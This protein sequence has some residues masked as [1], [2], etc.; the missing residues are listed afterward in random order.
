MNKLSSAKSFLL[1][2][3]VSMSIYAVC[4]HMLFI[5]PEGNNWLSMHIYPVLLLGVALVVKLV[6]G[7]RG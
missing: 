4:V 6:F 3:L 7:G 2:L 5:T 1:G